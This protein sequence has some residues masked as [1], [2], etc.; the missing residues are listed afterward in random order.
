MAAGIDQEQFSESKE[1]GQGQGQGNSR[2]RLVQRLMAATS[3][4]PQFLN[5]LLMA[6]AVH[7]AGTEAVCFMIEQQQ[8][9]ALLKLV[10][11]IRPDNSSPEIKKQAV[12]AFQEIVQPCVM[13]NKDG[14]IE[15]GQVDAG[16][17]TQ[18]CL[19]TLLRSEGNIVAVSAVITRCLDGERAKQRLMSMQLVAGY[20]DLFMLKRASEQSKSVA[21]SHQHV[22][23]LAT[24]AASSDGFENAAKN[25]CN[26]L[27]TRTGAVR[28]SLGWMKGDNIKIIALSHTE[29]FDKKQELIIQLQ[30]VMEECADQDSVVQ[31]EPGRTGSDNV[32]REAQMLSRAQ[33]GNGVLSLPLR[34]KDEVVG[35]VTLEFLPQQKLPEEATTGLAVAIDLVAPQLWDRHENDRWLITKTGLSLKHLAEETVGPR[36]MLA[37]GIVALSIIAVLVLFVWSPMYHVKAAFSFVAPEQRTVSA[38]YEGYID[39]VYVLPGDSVKAGQPLLDMDTRDI[40]VKKAEAMAQE[41]RAY[42]T[43]VKARGEQKPDEAGIADAERQQYAAEVALYDREISKAH[44]VAPIDG[45]ILS[46]D[47]KDKIGSAVKVGE[48]L[49]EVAELDGLQAKLNVEDRD[50]QD[51]MKVAK[52]GEGKLATTA[53]PWDKHAFTI[54]HIVPQGEAKEGSNVF[55]IYCNMKDAN[56]TWLPGQTGEARVD[57]EK[58]PLIQHWTGR[59]VDF[60]R[61]KLWM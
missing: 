52:V 43:M 36:H 12:Q 49:F 33:G 29:K 30:R 18:F 59:L 9:Q 41:R 61:L 60:L 7:V 48:Q 13:Q 2:S 23:Q 16:G 11:H 34:R 55:E 25:L 32:T 47:L 57:I 17:E 4:L 15:I 8:E 5:D 40:V 42:F 1:Q 56:P 24:A 51:I 21:E 44:I 45:K 26:E 54:D 50:M 37:K 14:A 27:A 10:N 31:F 35:V 28:V 58:R 19:V 38:P 22:L 39:K 3:N 6:Q 20:F 46:G 53:L